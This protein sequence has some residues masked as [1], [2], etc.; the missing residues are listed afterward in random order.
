MEWQRVRMNSR[1]LIQL[2]RSVWNANPCDGEREFNELREFRFRKEV[3]L[4]PLLERIAQ[5]ELVLEVGCGQGTDMLYCCEQMRE[6]S[7]YVAVDYSDRSVAFAQRAIASRGSFL[8]VTPALAIGNA[9]SLSFPDE[10]FDCVYSMGVLHHTSDTPQAI[11][12]VLRVL[13]PR[14]RAF[15]GLYRT[16]SPKIVIARVLRC[17]A[18]AVDFV[19]GEDRVIYR[20]LQRGLPSRFWGTNL[21][22]VFGV[23]VLSSYSKNGIKRLFKDFLVKNM[24][25]FGLGIPYFSLNRLIDIR[26]HALG[27][28][29]VIEAEKP[30]R[31]SRC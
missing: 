22:E 21:L 11:S 18:A 5:H 10:T 9:E 19:L 7:S 16:V 15:I 25:A 29:W 31:T 1:D 4:P 12:E 24:A 23:P 3:W 28:L 27:Y 8:K 30:L 6:G 26:P 20:A 13:K 14:G 17:F 2:T